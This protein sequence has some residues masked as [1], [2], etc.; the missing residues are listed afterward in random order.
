MLAVDYF[1]T[2]IWKEH[3]LITNALVHINKD[4]VIRE[5]QKMPLIQVIDFIR[6]V[7]IIMALKWDYKFGKWQFVAPV[8][9]K[10]D[11]GGMT[12]YCKY[13]DAGVQLNNILSMQGLFQEQQVMIPLVKKRMSN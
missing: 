11:G 2:G 4:N 3:G 12:I 8:E 13:G 10:T 6:K 5:G 7:N 9:I 1:L